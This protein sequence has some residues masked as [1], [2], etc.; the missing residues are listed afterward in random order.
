[1]NIP[2]F[3]GAAV[4]FIGSDWYFNYYV[5]V[6]SNTRELFEDIQRVK[7]LERGRGCIQLVCTDALI[8]FYI[9]VL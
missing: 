4:R 2:S 7:V 5:E 8:F 6:M 3:V 9:L 1:M